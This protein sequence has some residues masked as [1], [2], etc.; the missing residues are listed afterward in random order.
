MSSSS[1]YILVAML[2]I[3]HFQHLL[4]HLSYE[5]PLVEA[6]GFFGPTIVSH[7]RDHPIQY[8]PTDLC[9]LCLFFYSLR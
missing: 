5:T 7:V 8:E 9:L 3:E 6:T 1:V 2:Y 4:L